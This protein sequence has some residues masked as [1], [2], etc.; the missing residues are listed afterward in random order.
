MPHH[1]NPCFETSKRCPGNYERLVL[2]YVTLP[3]FTILYLSM[4]VSL[5]GSSTPTIPYLYFKQLQIMRI[6]LTK[7]LQNALL[8][9]TSPRSLFV[10]VSVLQK[11]FEKDNETLTRLE[12]ETR[13]VL[14][15]NSVS[16]TEQFFTGDDRDKKMEEDLQ[17]PVQGTEI[18]EELELENGQ[19]CQKLPQADRVY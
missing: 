15:A 17:T 14:L 4:S 13:S 11:R 2:P 7:G 5:G 12:E 18:L 3:P 1:Y 6:C 16:G 10:I 8:N 19:L 9:K